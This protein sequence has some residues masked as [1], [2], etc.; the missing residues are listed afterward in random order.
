MKVLYFSPYDQLRK[1]WSKS[2]SWFNVVLGLPT[3]TDHLKTKK[4]KNVI[5]NR[6]AI[7]PI[8]TQD[9]NTLLIDIYLIPFPLVDFE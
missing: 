5:L 8:I 4:K 2:H 9:L 7:I 6:K 3:D 1:S